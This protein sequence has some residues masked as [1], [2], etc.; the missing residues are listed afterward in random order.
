MIMD[1]ILQQCKGRIPRQ[2]YRQSSFLE[3][4]SGGLAQSRCTP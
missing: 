3:Q 1:F 4:T 2:R